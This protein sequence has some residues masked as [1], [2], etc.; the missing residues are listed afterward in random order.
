MATGYLDN[1]YARL[2]IPAN[3]TQEEIR[4]AYRRAALKFHPDRNK[5]QSANEIFLHIQEAYETLSNPKKRSAYDQLLPNDLV[6]PRNVLVNTIYSRG[7]L[8]VMDRPQLLYVMLNIIAMPEAPAA[9]TPHRAPLNLCLVLDTSTSMAGSRLEAVKSTALQIIASLTNEDVVSVV[10]F[11]DRPEVI[12][13]AAR[14]QQLNV[15][16]AR[17]SIITTGGGTEIGKGLEAGSNEVLR[18]L[19]TNAHNHIILI[20]DGR[21]YGDEQQCLQL[22]DTLAKQGI[23]IHTLGIGNQW[24]DS[25]LD[26]LA[27]KTGGSSEY[28]QT[29]DAIQKFLKEKFNQIEN[30]FASNVM[31]T[32]PKSPDIE[33][34]YAFRL[35]PDT[36]SI[37]IHDTLA[38]GDI[39]KQ[40]NLSIMLEFLIHQTPKVGGELMLLD[41]NLTYTIPSASIPEFSSRLTFSRPLRE[42]PSPEPP[43]QV[44]VRAMSRL[45]LYR[46]QEVAQVELQQGNV[47]K[48]ANRLQNLATQLLTSGENELAQTVML[49]LEQMQSKR[50]MTED[51]KKQIKYGTRALVMESKEEDF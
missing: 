8:T 42:N 22:A 28:A 20:T 19:R 2:G 13:P 33:M 34:R 39:P 40:R 1:F 29:S 51:A 35:S 31:L 47:H 36:S 17:I 48:A 24:N 37:A 38:L 23:T 9:M 10:T 26:A 16:E 21:T 41:G 44:L 15:L 5:D 25:F 30:N 27:S 46:L 7:S 43:P 50:T 6:T 3:A 18:N 11:N 32:Y 49:E 45:S 4:T 14:G 12:I